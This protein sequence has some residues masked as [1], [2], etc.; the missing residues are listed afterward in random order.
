MSAVR[1]RRTR[2][3]IAASGA[4]WFR[5]SK[6]KQKRSSFTKFRAIVAASGRLCVLCA[7]CGDFMIKIYQL[8]GTVN[9]YCGRHEWRKQ[10]DQMNCVYWEYARMT[11]TLY[12]SMLLYNPKW[13]AGSILMRV[14]YTDMMQIVILCGHRCDA[15]LCNWV[16]VSEIASG[17]AQFNFRFVSVSFFFSVRWVC[18]QRH[19]KN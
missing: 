18:G 10:R 9:G 3:V 1:R 7:D 4:V 5:Y 19:T 6:L 17:I 2:A 11:Y 8:I 16:C 14:L 13:A 12:K 15:T